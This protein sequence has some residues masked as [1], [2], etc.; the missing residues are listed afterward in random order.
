M[1]KT[2][3][4][5][6]TALTRALASVSAFA[7]AQ[8]THINEYQLKVLRPPALL[9]APEKNIQL[10][11]VEAKPMITMIYQPKCPWC[12][13]QSKTLAKIVEDCSDHITVNI[14]GYKGDKKTLKRELKHYAPILP[15]YLANKRFLRDVGGVKASPTTLFYNA[16][17]QLITKQ[18]GFIETKKLINAASIISNNQCDLSS[19]G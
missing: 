14:V 4:L 19:L 8:D 6:S 3:T 17:G 13:R 1:I 10:T 12:K 7:Q 18:R 11:P 5:K 9:A 2:N 16:K 15:A